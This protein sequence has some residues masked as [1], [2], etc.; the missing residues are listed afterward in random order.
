MVR[1]DQSGGAELPGEATTLVKASAATVPFKSRR[2]PVKFRNMKRI[3]I[4]IRHR[5]KTSAFTRT[6]L[7]VGLGVLALLACVAWP[8]LAAAN[9]KADRQRCQDNLRQIGKAFASWE[10]D[11]LGRAPWRVNKKDGGAYGNLGAGQVW[12]EFAFLTNGLP[13][14]QLLACPAD[15]VKPAS[16]WSRSPQG[17][18]LNAGYRANAVSY[19]IGLDVRPEAPKSL[20]S[21]D[22]NLEYSES[23][24]KCDYAGVNSAVSLRPGDTKVKWTEAVHGEPG[25][26]LFHDGSVQ[27]L[28]SE[29]LREALPKTNAYHEDNHT[30]MPR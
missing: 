16:N 11:H 21:G 23:G 30:L 12:V 17:G 6:D 14:P 24:Q 27:A 29:E 8:V 15:K 22:R 3:Q 9:P 5:K 1:L 18:Y 20:L 7:L 28:S 4:P 19:F 26:V 2:F 25:H 10:Q 13:T